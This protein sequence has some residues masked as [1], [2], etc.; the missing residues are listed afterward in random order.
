VFD[1]N[2]KKQIWQG[3]GKKTINENTK[4]RERAINEAVSAIMWHFP[5]K[6]VSGK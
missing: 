3:I 5:V 2:T 1:V 6:S 4:D